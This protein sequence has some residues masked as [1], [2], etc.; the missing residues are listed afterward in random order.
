MQRGVTVIVYRVH[1]STLGDEELRYRE[2]LASVQWSPSLLILGVDI[3]T[4]INQQLRD[5]LVLI[6]GGVVK[7][8]LLP[9]VLEVRAAHAPKLCPD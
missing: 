2:T 1:N 4:R 5:G 8:R 6:L 9:V 3:G 7:W